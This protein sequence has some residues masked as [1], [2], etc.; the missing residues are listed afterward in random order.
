MIEKQ[1]CSN[2]SDTI[3]ILLEEF[4]KRRQYWCDV[5]KRLLPMQCK[6]ETYYELTIEVH[7][8]KQ[9]S[10]EEYYKF[11]NDVIRI[12]NVYKNEYQRVYDFCTNKSSI[13]YPS[14]AA[15]T[16]KINSELSELI[17]KKELVESY[18]NFVQEVYSNLD[19][20]LWANKNWVEFKQLVHNGV[21][22]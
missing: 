5:L 4:N 19:K 15:K 8:Y 20:I 14:E 3:D 16:A 10:L 9:L 13:R 12:N 18:R 22:N 21:M 7:T 11:N 2:T 6:T 17:T 1:S